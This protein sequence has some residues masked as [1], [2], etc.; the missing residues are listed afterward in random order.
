MVTIEKGWHKP[1]DRG[2]MTN[3]QFEYIM[4]LDKKNSALLQGWNFNS[5][6]NAMRS[7]TKEDASDII[8][9][10][11]AGEAVEIA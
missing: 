10:L 7:L 1:T 11:K 9:A 6:T 8:E 4:V 3:A 2:A 5:K